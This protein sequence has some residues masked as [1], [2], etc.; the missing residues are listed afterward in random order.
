MLDSLLGSFSDLWFISAVGILI[1]VFF[2]GVIVKSMFMRAERNFRKGIKTDLLVALI[3]NRAALTDYHTMEEEH[4]FFRLMNSIV[5]VYYD[6]PEVLSTLL[7]IQQGNSDI[8]AV[9]NLFRAMSKDTDIDLSR[10]NQKLYLTPFRPVNPTDSQ[11]AP[12]NP[13]KPK[14]YKREDM[15]KYAPKTLMGEVSE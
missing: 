9:G 2:L 8:L 3:A 4:D 7:A 10:M 11:F 14:A 5:A 12:K 13:I 15:E 1:A 6:N